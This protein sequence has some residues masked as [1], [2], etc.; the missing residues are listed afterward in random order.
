ML[1]RR[2][3]LK[4]SGNV[5]AGV[6]MLGLTGCGDGT[7]ASGKT[8]LTFTTWAIPSEE[9]AFQA[10][11]D[12]YE[13]K[14]PNVSIKME[15]Q[16]PP[17]DERIKTRLASGEAPDLFRVSY[18]FIGQYTSEGALIDLS[19]YLDGDYGDAFTPSV[20]QTVQYQGRPYGLPHHT[21]TYALF[22]NTDYFDQLGIEVPKALDRCWS[23]DE[24][25]DVARRV[26][27]ETEAEYGFAMNW[28]QGN[29]YTWLPFLYMN[30]GQLLS[31]N[32]KSPQVSTTAAIEAI[33]YCQ[34]WFEDGLVPPNTSMKSTIPV[35]NLFAQGTI[36]MMLNGDWY[37][38]YLEDKM[39]DF[40]WDVTYM[41]CSVEKASDLGGNAVVVTRDSQAPEAAADFLKFLT[42]EEN[43]REFCTSATFIPVRKTLLEQEL[44]YKVRPQ[45]MELF[46][47]QSTTIPEHMAS[48]EALPVFTEINLVLADE[49]ELAFTSGQ[50]PE[51]TA[52]NIANDI[53]DA[54]SQ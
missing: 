10:V 51:K 21:D 32:L 11:I 16:P 17:I 49:L 41:P 19:D 3:F 25:T 4:A 23:W 45:A 43:M 35:E 47:E 39:K 54:L 46:L 8:Q 52:R 22:Y 24:F 15:V 1:T 48:V 38:P 6:G 40:G 26:K 30:G 14:N 9:D 29:G 13:A 33:A 5:L 27:E 44:D 12:K 2:D 20:W 50:S 37:L 31:D 36:G 42:N 53:E 7:G 34:S 18:Q 28:Q